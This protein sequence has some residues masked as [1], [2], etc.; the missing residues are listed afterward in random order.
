[1]AVPELRAEGITHNEALKVHSGMLNARE[2]RSAGK[3]DDRYVIQSPDDAAAYLMTEMNALTQ[4]YFV[5]L[6]L[7]VK[8]EVLHKKTVFYW[9]VKL[10][11]STSPGGG[12]P[13]RA[14]RKYVFTKQ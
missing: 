6:Y 1:M 2:M 3:A 11:D 10:F 13:I 4:E 8:N 7:N 5:V 14:F 9:L 12:A